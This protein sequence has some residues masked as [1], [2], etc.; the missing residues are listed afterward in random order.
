MA[1]NSIRSSKKES[2]IAGK[3]LR[4]KSTPKKEKGLAGSVLVNRKKKTK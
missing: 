4:K 1:K 2:H 3:T